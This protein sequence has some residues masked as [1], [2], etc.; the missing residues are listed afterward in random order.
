MFV[1]SSIGCLS[2][3]QLVPPTVDEDPSLPSEALAGT[4]LR[5]E[6]WGSPDDPLVVL[7]HGGPG[8]DFDG[9]AR[10]APLADD[11]FQ[12]LAF[13][14]RGA[15]RSRRHDPGSVSVDRLVDDVAELVERHSPDGSVILVGHSWGGMLA[16][17]TLGAY[18]ELSDRVVL[19]DPG[20][21]DGE[22][23]K[24]LGLTRIDLSAEPLNDLFWS[25]QMVSPDGHARLDW[26]FQQLVAGQT[27]AY[28]MSTDD[29]MPFRRYGRVSYD[30][31]MA[32][33]QDADGE[34]AWDFAAGV[35]DWS[36]TAH[37]VW[38]GANEIMDP[39]YRAAQEADWPHTTTTTIDGVGHDL[40]WVA[41]DAVL[42]HLR[43]VL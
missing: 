23:W 9:L 36:G 15:G 11:G 8:A 26:H 40:P 38:G 29:P 18:P 35:A 6:R 33:A 43:E 14:Q 19:L 31:V 42:A 25:E 30:D 7:L 27:P 24:S 3:S 34:P 39:A 20:P 2:V 13:D 22:R 16:A 41:A 28:R 10:L 4:S 12:V 17:A 21:F 5:V 37:F 32:S 1:W